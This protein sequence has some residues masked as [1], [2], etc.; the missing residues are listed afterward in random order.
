M[1]KFDDP[2]IKI[3]LI[4]ALLSLGIGFIHNDF[5][6]T[7]GIFAAIILA[8]GVAFWFEYDADKKFDILNQVGDEAPVKV[9]RNNQI[10][11]IPKKDVVVGDIVIVNTGD[12]IPADGELLEAI[13]LSI[14]ESSLTGEPSIKKTTQPEHFN[15]D[16]TYPS[17][18]VLRSTK[19]LEGNGILKVTNVGDN[20]E[21]GKVA[22]SSGEETQEET[23][24]NK[25]LDKLAK[26]I[27]I[28]GF[29]IADLT[30]LGLFLK[31]IFLG[32]LSFTTAQY[33]TTISL[34]I[35]VMIIIGKVWIPIIY[36]GLSVIKEDIRQPKLLSKS[37]LFWLLSGT[38]VLIILS[39]I[40]FIAGFNPLASESWIDIDSANRILQYFMVA[41]TLI[42]V[43]VP[44]GLPMS[45]TLS[46]ALS[47]RRMLKSNNLVRK[48]HATE[49]M[50]ATTVICTDKT[51]TLTQNQMS[52]Y[53]TS[54]ANMTS[55]KVSD[56]EIGQ[57]IR[58]SIAIN[59][60]AHLDKTDS[61][62]IKTIGNPTESAL[63]LWLEQQNIDYLKLREDND[64][65][66]QLSFSTE[67]IYGKYYF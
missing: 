32:N 7:I 29:I 54:F 43:T 59:S 19:V 2:I 4:A 24:L 55:Q 67:K 26:F 14:D 63:L 49:T 6:E 41:V 33:F 56:D 13:S 52:V 34:L 16:A 23:P 61:K 5:I 28:I 27:G 11:E 60:T 35:S 46:L 25:Q 58:E 8:T 10:T 47:M 37:W 53:E 50:G 17:N 30:F 39:G 51:G 45:V 22:K 42:V 1:E 38:F 66:D 15:P 36:D 65:I 12:E 21:Y 18:Y 48:M 31:D 20:T 57:L 64:L 40:I 9:I 62:K 3:L 44:E